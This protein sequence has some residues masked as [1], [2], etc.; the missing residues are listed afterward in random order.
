MG[1]G[2]IVVGLCSVRYSGGSVV[3]RLFDTALR[4]AVLP[5]GNERA[6]DYTR[7]GPTPSR[8]GDCFNYGSGNARTGSLFC[9]LSHFWKTPFER[10]FSKLDL[11]RTQMFSS[12][13]ESST[14]CYR[15]SMRAVIGTQL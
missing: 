14:H 5:P 9:R 15:Y 6:P 2:H 3:P 8:V 7:T 13:N 4:F 12:V 10:A 11:S 1:S